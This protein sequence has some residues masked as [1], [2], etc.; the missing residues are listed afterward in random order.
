MGT[1]RASLPS[2][3]KDLTRG[4]WPLP[5]TLASSME[6]QFWEQTTQSTAEEVAMSSPLLDMS[7]A[8]EREAPR[9]SRC[10][11][12]DTP[13]DGGQAARSTSSGAH[14]T[15]AAGTRKRR[16]QSQ[17]THTLFSRTSG[18]RVGPTVDATRSQLMLTEMDGADGR[19]KYSTPPQTFPEHNI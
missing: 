3:L 19:R 9:L 12:E 8:L 17:A 11:M 15:C 5:T 18:E 10:S 16:D 13:G 1:Q 4:E 7:Q 6:R 14:G 2:L